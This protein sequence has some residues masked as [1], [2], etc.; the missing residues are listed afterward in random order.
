M[1]RF[2]ESNA[3]EIISMNG[4]IALV[5]LLEPSLTIEIQ[6]EAVNLLTTL[7]YQGFH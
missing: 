1:D 3:R 4:V 6:T 2:Q 5:R 7:I